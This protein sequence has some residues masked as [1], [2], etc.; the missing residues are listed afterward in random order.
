[1]VGAYQHM[2]LEEYNH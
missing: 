1:M 2:R